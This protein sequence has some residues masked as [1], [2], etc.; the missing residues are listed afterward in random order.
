[1]SDCLTPRSP[2]C[3]SAYGRPGR[4]RETAADELF[5]SRGNAQAGGVITLITKREHLQ[6]WTA[7]AAKKSVRS[8][9]ALSS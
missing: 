5:V 9:I 1:M 3:D 8:V 6:L 2:A 7:A 4:V